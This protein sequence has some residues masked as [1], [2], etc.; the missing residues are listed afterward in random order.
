[1]M[2]LCP[3]VLPL[4]AIVLIL[5]SSSLLAMANPPGI[6]VSGT[7]GNINATQPTQQ[8]QQQQ[9]QG[10]GQGISSSDE[11]VVDVTF[12]ETS[13]KT[14]ESLHEKGKK[15]KEAKEEEPFLCS[16][17]CWI[18]IIVCGVTIG[19]I[20]VT[21]IVLFTVRYHNTRGQIDQQGV[22]MNAIPRSSIR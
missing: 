20:G 13:P 12:N 16:A 15:V 17:L 8:Q 7:D 6:E 9:Q 21:T 14:N 5:L 11:L 18:L 19:A 2:S 10:Q 3:F 22:Q 4:P 1:M